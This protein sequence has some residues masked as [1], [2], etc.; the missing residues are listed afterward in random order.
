LILDTAR[1]KAPAAWVS[2]EEL[3]RAMAQAKSED[4][5][6]TRGFLLIRGPHAAVSDN[7]SSA[8]ND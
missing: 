6:Q 7:P 3:F 5:P 4:T 1:Y 2:T 8:I